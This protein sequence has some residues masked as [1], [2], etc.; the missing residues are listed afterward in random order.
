MIASRVVR[1][2]PVFCLAASLAGSAP[3]PQAAEEHLMIQ[4]SELVWGPGPP[5]M[6]PGQKIAVLSGSPGQPGP[7]TLRAQ[8]P[9]GYKIPPHWHPADEHVTVISGTFAM[10]LGDKFE[11]SALHD[12]TPG[13]FAR[14]PATVRHFAL[15]KTDAVLQ[16]HG[17]GP[18]VLNYVNPADDPLQAAKK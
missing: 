14:M 13:G 17:T 15:A 9:A 18:L 16:I 10:G 2:V 3:A 5:M 6:P 8:V 7:F 4:Q 1:L 11:A 12:L